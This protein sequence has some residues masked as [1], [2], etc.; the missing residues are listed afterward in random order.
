MS[1]SHNDQAYVTMLWYQQKKGRGMKLIAYSSGKDDSNIEDKKNEKK[2]VLQRP[3]ILKS[4][5][6]ITKAAVQDSAMYFCASS[7]QLHTTGGRSDKNQEFRENVQFP[8]TGGAL[9]FY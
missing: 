6:T 9:S 4:S 5:L 8:P 2:L 7:A 3:D 1:C